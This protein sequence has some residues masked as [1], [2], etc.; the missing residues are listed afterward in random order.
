MARKDL[1][2]K[3]LNASATSILLVG[4]SSPSL[5]RKKTVLQ[6]HGFDIT[7]AENICYAEVFAETQ[8]FDAAVYDDALPAH[9]QLSLARVMRI[10]WPW[11]RLISCGPAP[12]DG[13]F[14]ANEFSEAALPE[15]LREVL[16]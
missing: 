3:P 11:M 8:H 4:P 15:T 12:S 9:E 5:L 14:D 13:L 16:D 7:L 2:D 1:V 6:R 10:R